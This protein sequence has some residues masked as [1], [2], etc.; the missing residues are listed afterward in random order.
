LSINIPQLQATP[1]NVLI[2]PEYRLETDHP[3]Y[4]IGDTVKIRI[5]VANVNDEPIV[6]RIDGGFGYYVYDP[7]N[8]RIA[9]NF[10]F[11]KVY[12]NPPIITSD[13]L[14]T[15]FRSISLPFPPIELSLAPNSEL[16]IETLVWDT[17]SNTLRPVKAGTYR[18]VIYHGKCIIGEATIRIFSDPD[19]NPKIGRFIFY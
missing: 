3:S 14:P 2:I 10:V 7:N 9:P 19:L 18:I 11:I 6:I 5:Y 16:Y 15:S 17:Q 1:T 8:N 13:I 4:L 12:D